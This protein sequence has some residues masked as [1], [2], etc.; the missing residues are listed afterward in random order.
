MLKEKSVHNLRYLSFQRVAF[1]L[2][3]GRWNL[4]DLSK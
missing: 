2:E 4:R 3:R 1:N